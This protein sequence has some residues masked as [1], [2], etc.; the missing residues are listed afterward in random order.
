VRTANFVSVL[1]ALLWGFHNA[2]SGRCFPY[3][4]IAEKADCSRAS[5]YNAINAL[6]RAGI[7]P[8]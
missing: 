7:I 4:R 3:K 1:G 2:Q 6:E 5:V 8:R